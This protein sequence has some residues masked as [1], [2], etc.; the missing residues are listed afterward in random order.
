MTQNVDVRFDDRR[1]L[2]RLTEPAIY[3]GAGVHYYWRI[4]TDGG[5]TVHTYKLDP[6]HG[7]YQPTGTFSDVIDTDEPWQMSIP[8]KRLTPRHFPSEA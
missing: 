5:I 1:S 6:V 2:D 4:E 3:A 7:S 8:I